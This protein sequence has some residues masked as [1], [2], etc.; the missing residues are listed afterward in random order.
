MQTN[1]VKKQ[2]NTVGALKKVVKRNEFI[3]FIVLAA[4]WI[5]LRICNEGF[6]SAA[7]ILTIIKSLSFYGI[8]A[9]GM[10]WVM[11]NGDIDLSVGAAASFGSVF[12]TWFMLKTNCFGMMNG[13]SEWLGAAMC[14][15]VTLVIAIAIG[16]LNG[17]MMVTLK[18]PAFIATVAMKYTLSGVVVIITNGTP[19]YPLPASFDAFGK[20][21]IPIAGAKLSY[22][23]LIMLALIIASELILRF[24][25]FGRSIYATGSNTQAAKL[26]GINTSRVRYI[27]LMVVSVLAAF[28]GSMNAAYI[29]QGSIQV[30]TDWEMMVIATCVIGGVNMSG[31]AG[32][33][34]GVFIG[35]FI[36]NTLNSAI[37]MMGVNPF[38]QEVLLGIMLMAIVAIDAFR[39][40]RKIKA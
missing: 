17:V 10:S 5:I 16:F 22:F 9:A 1:T 23:F 31:G 15:A 36:I 40:K 39:E 19:V 25:T 27:S 33:L 21:G 28:A 3:L 20:D 14:V 34:V 13:E 26:S 2:N 38:L 35:L 24:T 11:I 37:A 6:T 29:G 32:N 12:S 30:G 8:V 7:N 4:M 18:L